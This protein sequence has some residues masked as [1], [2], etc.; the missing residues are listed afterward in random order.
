MLGAEISGMDP[1]EAVAGVWEGDAAMSDRLVIKFGGSSAASA[2]LTPWITAIERAANPVVVV[3]GGGPFA[4]TV[5][6][7]QPR[8]GYD[9]EAAHEM[10]ILGMEQFGT[11]LISLGTRLVKATSEAEIEAALEQ[12]Q[13]PVW[14]PLDAVLADPA[15]EKDWTVTS[16]SLAAWLA[17]RLGG[18]KLCLLKQI[19]VPA[20][21]TVDALIG[22]QIVDE[23]FARLLDPRTRVFVAGPN[24]LSAAGKRFAEGGIPGRE[25]LRATDRSSRAAV[26]PVEQQNGHPAATAAE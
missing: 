24:E 14:M 9:D 8:M 18:I 22:A 23:S 21:S 16:D 3:P 17:G 19:D 4:D 10:A 5:R 15:I 7:Y 1:C 20:H 6:R 12:D 13:I 25:V 26:H 11:A 2:A